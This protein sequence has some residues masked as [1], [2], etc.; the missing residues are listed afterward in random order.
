MSRTGGGLASCLP[1]ARGSPS[2]PRPAARPARR[3]R[4]RVGKRGFMPRPPGLNLLLRTLRTALV[5][6]FVGARRAPPRAVVCSRQY[7]GQGTTRLCDRTDIRATRPRTGAGA[8]TRRG[9]VTLLRSCS[10]EAVVARSGAAAFLRKGLINAPPFDH[11]RGAGSGLSPGRL[12]GAGSVRGPQ[13]GSSRG[14]SPSSAGPFSNRAWVG[15]FG[16]RR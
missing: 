3:A 4:R 7:T 16:A 5:A 12:R 14:G 2:S 6:D 10:L 9:G 13:E 15:L 11:L 8:P 1:W